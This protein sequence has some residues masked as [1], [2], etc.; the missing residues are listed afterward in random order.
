MFNLQQYNTYKQLKDRLEKLH[1]EL[2]SKSGLQLIVLA[3][4]IRIVK[5]ELA[6]YR[7]LLYKASSN[8]QVA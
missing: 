8:N 1:I 6:S 5:V 7:D 3:Q 4:E 2:K